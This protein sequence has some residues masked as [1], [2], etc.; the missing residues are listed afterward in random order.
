MRL[1]VPAVA[2]VCGI[3]CWTSVRASR[4]W[5]S[6]IGLRVA[7]RGLALVHASG[8]G[9]FATPRLSSWRM[10]AEWMAVATT[11]TLG[12]I[13]TRTLK[14]LEQSRRA[15]LEAESSDSSTR[16]PSS[17]N[18]TKRCRRRTRETAEHTPPH[19]ARLIVE[20]AAVT[21][22]LEPLVAD[23]QREWLSAQTSAARGVVHV[24]G[25]V[26]FV[27]SAAYCLATEKTPRDLHLRAWVTLSTF[28]RLG[29]LLLTIPFTWAQPALLVY[30][31]AQQPD[32]E[33]AV[34]NAAVGDT[35]G[36]EHQS[37]ERP[38]SRGAARP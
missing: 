23:W 6:S 14:R 11:V 32:V 2:V 9:G 36:H 34:C 4:L 22:V 21:R 13:P 3:L 19:L 1:M 16:S 24:R 18:R 38:P 33:P 29:L 17:S 8:C 35:A 25:S 37:R 28:S 7:H 20:P 26:A 15:R 12:L 30:V 10:A 27:A 5:T 31:L